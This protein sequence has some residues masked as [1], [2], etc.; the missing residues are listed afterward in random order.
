MFGLDIGVPQG[1]AN[2][3]VIHSSALTAG[4]SP[5]PGAA[6]ERAQTKEGP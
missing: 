3:S 6:E 1:A 5:T 4:S 2:K